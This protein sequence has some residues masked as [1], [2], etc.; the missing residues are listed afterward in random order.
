[1]LVKTF[2]STLRGLDAIIVT[3]EVN[4]GGPHGFVLTG[5]PDNAVRE[6]RE[7]IEAALK[8]NRLEYPRGKLTINMAPADVRKEGSNFDLTLAVGILA[9]SGQVRDDALGDYVV[10]GE[11]ALDGTVLP[12]RGALPVAIEA[13]AKGFK[14]FILPEANAGEAGV[15]DKL[16]VHPVRRLTEVVEFLNG[17]RDIP[18][19]N[20]NTRELFEDGTRQFSCDFS[21]VKGQENVKRALEV[22]AAGA[23]NVIMVGPP[24]AGK[25]MMAKRVP[26]ILP[27]MTLAEALETTKIHSV[28]G[29]LGT[30]VGLMTER[31]FRTPHHTISDV[32]LV[33]G[34]AN[35]MPGEIS[36]AHN[37]VL[38]L[39]ELP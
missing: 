12:V 21:E 38:F 33:G 7:R 13:R 39:D 34:G 6:S 26:T 17:K 37:G 23:H 19:A 11:L 30:R 14:G 9:A 4:L 28:A 22:A 35:A 2:G 36:L 5:L 10:M 20:I 31:P 8:N 24:G 27:P 15:V 18:P 32:A 1:M 29:K 25:S 16:A 3:V